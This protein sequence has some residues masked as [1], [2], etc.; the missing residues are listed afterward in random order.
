[1]PH[2]NSLDF[3]YYP[4]EC[5]HFNANFWHYIHSAFGAVN[6]VAKYYEHNGRDDAGSGS[7]EGGKERE[8]GDGESRPTGVNT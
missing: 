4:H 6:D 7:C 5:E 3:T 1:M 8:D 2:A